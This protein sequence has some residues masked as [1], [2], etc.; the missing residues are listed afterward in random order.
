[1]KH[2][3]KP[4]LLAPAGNI[5]SL[6]AAI[7]AGADAVYLGLQSFNMRARAKNFTTKD[8]PKIKELCKPRNIKIYLTLN[9]IAYDDELKQIEKI[10]KTSKPYVNAIICS[11][12]AVMQLAKKH[13]IPFHV[14]TQCSVSN[15]KSAEFYK[16]LGAERIVLARELNIKQ[17]KKISKII[18]TEVF[19]HGAMC[20]S[21]SGRCLLS[22]FCFGKSAN[23]GECIQPCR[24]PY[25]NVEDAQGNKLRI[26]NKYILSP[27]DLC[28]LPFIEELKKA[29][30][31]SFKIE[32]RNKEP[33]YV[34][35]V[36]NVYREAIDNKLTKEQ[37]KN[38]IQELNKVYNKGFSSGFYF[39]EPGK[40]SFSKNEHSSA[41]QSKQFIGKIS[42]Y[43]PKINVALLTL[44]NGPLRIGDEIII[45]GKTTGIVKS[46]IKDMEIEHKPIKIARKKETIAIKLPKCRKNDMLYKVIKK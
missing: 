45:L 19:I 15:S 7:S 36:I 39:K 40:E 28:T 30:I 32:G 5:I 34:D 3:T 42:H 31:T 10:I 1:M 2:P 24:R 26:E 4:E 41:T 6:R 12:L 20:I 16:K 46:K 44:N 22:Q 27:K 43:Y 14:S 13:K 8:L 9:T 29:G 11:D 18:P 38:S 37:I 17:I 25:V 35:T 23:R 21:I 33:E